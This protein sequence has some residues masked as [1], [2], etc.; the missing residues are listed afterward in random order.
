MMLKNTNV[1]M[2]YRGG[3]ARKNIRDRQIEMYGNGPGEIRFPKEVILQKCQKFYVSSHK[4][5]YCIIWVHFRPSFLRVLRQIRKISRDYF[6]VRFSVDKFF[7]SHY[8]QGNLW[9]RSYWG[10]IEEGGPNNLLGGARRGVRGWQHFVKYFS[11]S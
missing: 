3:G 9:L 1:K 5:Q 11:G 8:L 6:D 2:W 7:Y 10:K 4:M